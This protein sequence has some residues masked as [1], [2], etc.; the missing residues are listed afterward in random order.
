MAPPPP[1][2]ALMTAGQAGSPLGS[3]AG[4]V[5]VGGVASGSG[6]EEGLF[7]RAER[8][9]QQAMLDIQEASVCKPPQPPA[10]CRHE[11]WAQ[12]LWHRCSD[13]KSTGLPT[14]WANKHL[15]LRTCPMA[16]LS[17]L[18]LGPLVAP[19]ALADPTPLARCCPTSRHSGSCAPAPTPP[20]TSQMPGRWR[21]R[22]R[23]AAGACVGYSTRR[24]EQPQHCPA[25]ASSLTLA[26]CRSGIVGVCMKCQAVC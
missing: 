11:H 12:L 16:H 6:G 25:T 2:L 20:W 15:C 8:A 3:D 5:L 22:R 7:E 18:V 17:P 23:A 4:I 9:V 26:M 10:Q 19:P 24:R 21:R 14:S 1:L 13:L